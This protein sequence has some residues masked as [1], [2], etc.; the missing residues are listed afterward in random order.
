MATRY[1]FTDDSGDV[2]ISGFLDPEPAGTFNGGT[3][4]NPL[5]I[6]PSN[7]DAIALTIA[8]VSGATADGTSA[9]EVWDDAGNTL[10]FMT[11]NGRANLRSGTH[12]WVAAGTGGSSLSLW[13]RPKSGG[14]LDLRDDSG[15]STARIDTG[16]DL[17]LG[18]TG[19]GVGFYGG[20]PV[21][22]P[23]VTGAKLP[24]DVVLASLLTALAAQ[25]LIVDSST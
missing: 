19:K 4:T 15:V 17:T 20:S 7:K 9:I 24:S 25:G 1:T 12:A 10:D 16:G 13:L 2:R 23:T 18:Q 14:A 11:A 3:I 8:P 22:Q 6:S 21:V 5:I